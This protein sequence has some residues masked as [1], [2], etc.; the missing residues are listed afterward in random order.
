MGLVPLQGLYVL[1]PRSFQLG[2]FGSWRRQV[3]V[4]LP[5]AV[6][7]ETASSNASGAD[8]AAV[9]PGARAELATDC[10]A[11]PAGDALRVLFD[12]TANTNA[13]VMNVPIT[14]ITEMPLR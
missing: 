14:S 7:S 11:L 6:S 10:F 3:K 12:N 13:L 4:R 8:L 2:P 5:N 9:E 1:T